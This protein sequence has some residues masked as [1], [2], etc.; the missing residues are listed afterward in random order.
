MRNIYLLLLFVIL[1]RFSPCICTDQQVIP[2]DPND[3]ELEIL[4]EFY[5]AT[6]GQ[7]W[8]QQTDWLNISV[9]KCQ[10]F[11]ISCSWN[12]GPTVFSITLPSN[13]LQGTFPESFSNMTYLTQLFLS[14][15]GLTGTLPHFIARMPNLAYLDLNS[16]Y[17]I[18]TIPEEY[19]S[20]IQMQGKGVKRCL[21]IH[22]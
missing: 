11:G 13:N 21:V 12:N 8:T 18:G 16:N 2:I 1:C 14:S 19:G 7:K 6:G 10:W 4:R 17:F 5:Y 22:F 3:P 9:S 20:M 15:N